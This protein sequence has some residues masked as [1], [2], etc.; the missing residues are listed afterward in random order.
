MIADMK[1]ALHASYT[2]LEDFCREVLKLDRAR[3]RLGNIVARV[4]DALAH[5]IRDVK[6][7]TTLPDA[8]E[9]ACGQ[10]LLLEFKRLFRF[11]HQRQK[12]PKDRFD[13]LML[14]LQSRILTLAGQED[15]PPK[16]ATLGKRRNKQGESIFRFLFDPA[17]PPTNNAAEQGNRGSVID[18]RITQGSRSPMGR[19]WNAR[20]WTV[21]GTC[22][23]QGRSAWRFLQ[24]AFNAHDLQGVT[25]S[26]LPKP[27]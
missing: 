7:L 13:R 20:T 2:G 4:S 14:R 18:R 15:L 24:E 19:Q 21:L 25:P 9:K 6:F 17:G 8:G 22:R 1:G 26:L 10:R 11:W 16:S 12:I 5:L 3:C 23:K 27:A